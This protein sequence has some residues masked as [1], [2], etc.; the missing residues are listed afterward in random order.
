MTKYYFKI[1]RYNRTG[2][3]TKYRWPS[4]GQWTSPV[5]GRLI[6]CRNGYHVCR[7]RDIHKWMYRR[8][9]VDKNRD[10]VFLVEVAGEIIESHNKVVVRRA[11]LIKEL[12]FPTIKTVKLENRQSVAKWLKRNG[13][14][15]LDE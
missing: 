14:V 13:I 5:E 15:L 7:P 6:A 3:Y 12:I 1:L 10:R 11:K 9:P 4:L 2:G 8:S